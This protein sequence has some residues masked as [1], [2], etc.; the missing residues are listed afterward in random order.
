[1]NIN[2]LLKEAQFTQPIYA[3]HATDSENLKSILK[4]GMIPNHREDGYGSNELSSLGYSLAPQS[5][6]Y[7]TRDA[8]DVIHIA[9]SIEVNQ[10]PMIIVCKIQI[11]DAEMDED[12]LTSNVIDERGLRRELKK[13]LEGSSVYDP[14]VDTTEYIDKLA[15]NKTDAIIDRINIT[16]TG[17]VQNIKPHIFNYVKALINFFIESNYDGTFNED[18]VRHY[19]GILTKKLKRYVTHNVSHNETFKIDKKIGF[20]GASKIVGIFLMNH[21]SNGVSWGDVG[22]LTGRSYHSYKTPMELVDK[23]SKR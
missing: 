16:N 15:S 8:N 20:S 2:E 18:D 21:G 6:V 23:N 4:H 19:Q 12:R 22:R 3:Y 9:K 7:F 1:M 13:E 17:F 10:S 5:G 11:K 14:D